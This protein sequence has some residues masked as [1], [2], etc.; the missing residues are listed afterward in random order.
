MAF[1]PGE[2]KI[3]RTVL[4]RKINCPL[5]TSVGRLF[6]AVAA[7]TGLCRKTRFEGQAAMALEFALHGVETDD[8]Y[9]FELDLLQSPGSLDWAHV[10]EEVIRDVARGLSTGMISARFH[11]GLAEAI[12]AVAGYANIERV[13]L[14]GGCFQNRYLAERAVRRL[15]ASGFLPYWHQR[16]PPNDGGIALGQLIATSQ[17]KAWTDVSGCTG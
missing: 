15:K 1:A 5:T 8:A 4:A 11:N 13:V 9:S 7:I 6:D 14:T 16:V 12:I 10:F 17:R 2:L 3:L